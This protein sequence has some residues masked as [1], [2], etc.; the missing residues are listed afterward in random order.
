MSTKVILPQFDAAWNFHEGLA[1]VE[2]N[3]KCGFVDKTG[4]IVI[5]LQKFEIP[6]GICF[7]IERRRLED[8]GFFEGCALVTVGGK[9]GFLNKT[10]R[11]I[12][13]PAK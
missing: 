4:S 8:S 12:G 3:G 11:F 10:G 9:Y 5:G 1:G 6:W 2:I 13:K 7:D